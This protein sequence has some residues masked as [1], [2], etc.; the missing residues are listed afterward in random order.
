[1][2]SIQAVRGFPHMRASGIVP[3]I[4][5]FSRQGDPFNFHKMVLGVLARH[6]AVLASVCL[7]KKRLD[8]FTG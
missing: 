5:S 3:C 1:M 2:L 7:R 4:V 8:F 6:R